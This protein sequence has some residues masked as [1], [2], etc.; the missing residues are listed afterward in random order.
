MGGRACRWVPCAKE[1]LH[2]PMVG[3]DLFAFSAAEITPAAPEKPVDLPEQGPDAFAEA[4]PELAGD[5]TASQVL[6]WLDTLASGDTTP[7][8]PDSPSLAAFLHELPDLSKY[9]AEGSYP[10]ERAAVAWL[11][12]SKVSVDDVTNS[13]DFLNHFPDRSKYVAEGSCSDN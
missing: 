6:S 13:T 9:V 4:C 8:G 11:G 12:D 7:D 5:T 1:S 3:L 10:K 2:R